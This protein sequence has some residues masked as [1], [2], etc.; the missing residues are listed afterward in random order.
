MSLH[1]HRPPLAAAELDEVIG[2]R[3]LAARCA[4]ALVNKRVAQ[5]FVFAGPRG[6]GQD[7]DARILA[8]MLTASGGPTPDPCVLPTR[9]P[10]D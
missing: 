5:A 9:Q 3:A 8:R 7:H 6:V 4:T 1:R 10:G 2:Q